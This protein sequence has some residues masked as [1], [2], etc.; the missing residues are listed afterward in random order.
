[1]LHGW[2][3]SFVWC[4]PNNQQP[5]RQQLAWLVGTTA[6]FWIADIAA[7]PFN[8]NIYT[9]V[10]ISNLPC[11]SPETVETS[12]LRFLDLDGLEDERRRSR[13]LS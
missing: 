11:Q 12:I 1:V 3:Q 6:P 4:G 7:Q 9:Y 5:E 8:L 10:L 2:A 13:L